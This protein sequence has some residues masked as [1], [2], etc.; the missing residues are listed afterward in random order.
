MRWCVE[1]AWPC[2][3]DHDDALPT[4][5]ESAHEASAIMLAEIL[6]VSWAL[7]FVIASRTMPRHLGTR[8][9][10]GME[11]WRDAWGIPTQLV[12]LP[13]LFALRAD[14]AFYYVFLLYLTMDFLVAG[15]LTPLIKAHHVVCLLGHYLSC[16][17]VPSSFSTYFAGVVSLEVGSGCTNV[18]LLGHEA[19]WRVAFFAVGMTLSNGAAS[20]V[21]WQYAHLDMD[22][23]VK[24]LCLF[25]TVSLIVLRQQACYEGVLYGPDE[26]R[27][28]SNKK[29]DG[30]SLLTPAAAALLVPLPSSKNGRSS[31][32]ATPRMLGSP[33]TCILPDLYLGDHGSSIGYK[34]LIELGITHVLNV[35]GGHRMPPA[36]YSEKLS[37]HSVPLSDFGDDDLQVRVKECFKVLE[38]CQ[39]AGG[40]CLVHCSQGVNR[41]PSVVVA[42]LMC[43]K[44]TRWS[45]KDAWTHVKARRDCVSPHYLYFE[46]LQK[47]ECKEHRLLK[48]SISEEESGIFVPPGVAD[49]RALASAGQ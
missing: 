20:Y 41:S 37:L 14:D 42:W 7:S 12:L 29:D 26:L 48:P 47:I 25:I 3:S 6:A 24:G 35:K 8:V 43:S 46:K 18:W 49:E 15:Y 44:R 13:L 11:R 38:A 10:G 33:P 30:C 45:L 21:A 32:E 19:P 5:R 23:Y 39:K 1:S 22:Y 9:I 2:S 36:Q 17:V 4:A 40:R 28:E 31:A 34:M 27:D 16:H